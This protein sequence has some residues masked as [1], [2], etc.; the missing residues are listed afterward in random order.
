MAQKLSPQQQRVFDFIVAEMDAGRG[1]PSNVAI[2]RHMGWKHASSA[3]DALYNLA[4]KRWL[5][6]VPR[7]K[8]WAFEI[9]RA[10]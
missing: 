4:R 5:R 2:A 7:G 3:I 1:F 10:G 9:V 8:G 6:S